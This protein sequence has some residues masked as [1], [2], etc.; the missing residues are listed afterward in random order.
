M[1]GLA[2]DGDEL[3]LALPSNYGIATIVMH[4]VSKC[5]NFRLF[6]C[7]RLLNSNELMTIV[8]S[9]LCQ[10]AIRTPWHQ[11]TLAS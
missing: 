3:V 10:P 8:T 9:T 7:R 4:E 5:K 11:N 6:C 1:V 2:N